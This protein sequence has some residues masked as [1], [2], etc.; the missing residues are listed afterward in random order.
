[1]GLDEILAVAA[2]GN[3]D[4][5][6][7]EGLLKDRTPPFKSALDELAL[8]LARTY[9]AGKAQFGNADVVASTMFAYAAP[10]GLLGDTLHGV[11][12]AFDAGEFV[13]LGDDPDTDVEAKYTR[14]QLEKI[15]ADANAA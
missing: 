6:D 13:P 2:T 7:I 9:L 8:E 1:V 5:S 4:A 12:L 14:P 15:L 11:F 10:R 3:L